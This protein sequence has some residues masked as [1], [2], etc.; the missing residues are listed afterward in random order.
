MRRLHKIYN[1]T[2]IVFCCVCLGGC[3]AVLFINAIARNVGFPIRFANDLALALF[4]YTTFVGADLAYR[5]NRLAR[6][7]LFSRYLPKKAQTVLEYFILAVCLALFV[8][9]AYLGVQLALRSWK[10][11]VPSL[12]NISYGWIIISVPI[13]AVLMTISTIIKFVET[14]KGVLAAGKEVASC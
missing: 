13:G 14:T 5:N 12:P 6:V 7:D 11:P 9:L 1:M 8:L 10:R 3:M 2:E 4:S